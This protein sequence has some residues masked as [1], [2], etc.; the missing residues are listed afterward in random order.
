M[1]SSLLASLKNK[2]APNSEQANSDSISQAALSAQQEETD[3][4]EEAAVTEQ[5]KQP[6]IELKFQH[7]K[8]ARTAV[9]L[10]TSTGGKV[11]FT[12]YEFI[13]RDEA[14]IE[15]LDNEIAKGLPGI[16]KGALLTSSEA[17]PMEALKRKHFAEFQAQQVEAATNKAL[18][19]QNDMGNNKPAGSAQINP[20]NTNDV[21]K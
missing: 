10:I 5:S 12:G 18:G 13:T 1:E 8:S 3:V 21:A 2:V 14:I 11:K 19:V 4:R 20:A 7:Y 16:V 6:V 9:N 15:Y 17:N